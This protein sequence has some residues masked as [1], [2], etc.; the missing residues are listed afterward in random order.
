MATTHPQSV[1]AQNSATAKSRPL[2]ALA[3]IDGTERTGRVIDYAVSLAKDGRQVELV[4][5]GVVR[6]PPDGRLRGYG[7]FKRDEIHA[8]LKDVIGQRAV[9]A[10]ARRLDQAGIAHRDR[11][12]VGDPVE[13]ILSVTNEEGCDLVVVGDAPAGAIARWLPKAVGLSLA[14]VACQIIQQTVV[15]VVVVK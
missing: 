13:T 2:R 12:E 3:V 14:T 4:L 7:S 1:P 10:A 5:L 6:Q 8:R 11:I 9:N 15:P